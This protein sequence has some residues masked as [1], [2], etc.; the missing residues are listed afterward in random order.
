LLTTVAP[1]RDFTVESTEK[2]QSTQ[3]DTKE[4]SRISKG[5]GWKS[6]FHACRFKKT[7]VLFESF[8]F[9]PLFAVKS[10]NPAD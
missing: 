3:S 4:G 5:K 6:S 9:K 1:N 2:T 10:L 8:V 7:F